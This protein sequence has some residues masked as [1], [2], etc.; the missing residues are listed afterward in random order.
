MNEAG[1]KLGKKKKLMMSKLQSKSVIRH[2]LKAT[3]CSNAMRV[4]DAHFIAEMAGDHIAVHNEASLFTK[5]ALLSF[6]TLMNRARAYLL[7]N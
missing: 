7:N 3:A 1:I 6:T 5:G 4:P 2:M